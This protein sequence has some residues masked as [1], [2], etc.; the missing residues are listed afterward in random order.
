[1]CIRDSYKFI[2][3]VLF[4]YQNDLDK[5]PLALCDQNFDNDVKDLF[6]LY[7]STG[8]S[9]E[10]VPRTCEEATKYSRWFSE[11]NE[12]CNIQKFDNLKDF[13]KSCDSLKWKHKYKKFSDSF[14]E[15]KRD[16]QRL[17]VTCKFAKDH[18]WMVKKGEY[19]IAHTNDFNKAK[20]DDENNYNVW[21]S[22]L[23]INWICKSENHN[24]PYVSK[25][26]SLR[27]FSREEKYIYKYF[28]I[29][30]F[31]MNYLLTLQRRNFSFCNDASYGLVPLNDEFFFSLFEEEN[32]S[33]T[34]SSYRRLLDVNQS[35]RRGLESE[36]TIDQAINQQCQ[37]SST[38][39]PKIHLEVKQGNSKRNILQL[40]YFL[41]SF[42]DHFHHRIE[43][44][45]L[46]RSAR[47]DITVKIMPHICNIRYLHFF[48]DEYNKKSSEIV[49]SA[50]LNCSQSKIDHVVFTSVPRN[51]LETIEEKALRNLHT[52]GEIAVRIETLSIGHLYTVVKLL[53]MNVIEHRNLPLFRLKKIKIVTNHLDSRICQR[54]IL[55]DLILYLEE[56]KIVPFNGY[57]LNKEV[58]EYC[59]KS[60]IDIVVQ[61]SNITCLLYT[62]P[63]P[64]DATL[65][66]MPSSA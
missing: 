37:W 53:Q 41:D 45:Q 26:C 25:M 60:V 3:E 55:R 32:L 20:L 22:E 49:F 54:S 21:L 17:R 46:S 18:L 51:N 34:K 16:L 7:N 23:I 10:A 28:I 1:M 27:I 4:E 13:I 58:F 5:S 9:S 6:K 33:K 47:S 12:Y 50:L 31:V 52:V 66:R 2:S 42:G 19:Y 15:L 64:R 62:S 57:K 24:N 14:F 36:L 48:E 44:L 59:K 56:I 43:F 11:L 40:H 63:S 8:F 38:G 65:S 61:A 35:I 30:L 39:C 29:E